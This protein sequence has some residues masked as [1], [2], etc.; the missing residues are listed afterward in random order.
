VSW[1]LE[2]SLNFYRITRQAEWML[3]VQRD[4][5]NGDRQYYAIMTNDRGEIAQRRLTVV[6]RGPVSGTVLAT[7]R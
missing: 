6:Y 3:P 5:F 2:P 4:G 1:Q 7:A